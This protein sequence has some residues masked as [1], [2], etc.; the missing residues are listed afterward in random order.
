M[1]YSCQNDLLVGVRPIGLLLAMSAF[2][3]SASVGWAHKIKPCPST[4]GCTI[5]SADDVS[6][7]IMPP[8]IAGLSVGGPGG[9]FHRSS[10][11]VDFTPAKAGKRGAGGAVGINLGFVRPGNAMPATDRPIITT[12]GGDS[13][14]IP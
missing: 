5:N 12:K 2:A 7:A 14:V 10:S 11:L 1:T 4:G 13:T 9:D 8:G 6:G 3:I